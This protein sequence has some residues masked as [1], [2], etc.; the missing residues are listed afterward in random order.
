MLC[1]RIGE[2][3][4]QLSHLDQA[5]VSGAVMTAYRDVVGAIGSS[6]A[7][8]RIDHAINTIAPIDRF[9][10]SEREDSRR[11]PYLI[12]HRLE[13]VLSDRMD[14][15]MARYF[16][17]D[18]VARAIEA[19][20][21]SGGT[22]MMRVGPQDITEAEYRRPFFEEASIVERV[23]FVQRV[24]DRWL[25]MNVA[26]RAPMPRFSDP[27]LD[28]L[29]SLSLLLLPLAA[30]QAK[31]DSSPRPLRNPSAAELE[32]R[33]AQLFPLLSA[34]ERQVC[35]RTAIGMTSEATALDLGIGIGSVQTYRKR[36]FQRLEIS[37]AFQLAP[38]V[39]H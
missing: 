21:T 5:P 31:L 32:E 34:R 37:S 9:Y 36:A 3:D 35:A 23:S 38:L 7:G 4:V 15:Y 6:E 10:V 11:P 17:R 27:E 26:R 39:M 12:A 16:R 33:F 13:S 19:A 29:A 8:S 25:I 2:K 24:S 20:R 1:A 22:V 28:A 30:R 14:D 18:P